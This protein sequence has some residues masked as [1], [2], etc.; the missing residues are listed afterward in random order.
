MHLKFVCFLSLSPF[1]TS[2]N[3]AIYWMKINPEEQQESQEFKSSSNLIF[4]ILAFSCDL[5]KHK[6]SSSH[7]ILFCHRYNLVSK[8]ALKKQLY[9]ITAIVLDQ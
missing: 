4:T 1:L 6:L 7:V 8:R 2:P 3:P 9:C 5:Y